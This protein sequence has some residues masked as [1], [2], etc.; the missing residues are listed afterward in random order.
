MNPPPDEPEP[1]DHEWGWVDESFSH[2]LGLE[3]IRYFQC[4]KCGATRQPTAADLNQD[5]EP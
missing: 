2:D 3:I 1:C 5:K 4:E